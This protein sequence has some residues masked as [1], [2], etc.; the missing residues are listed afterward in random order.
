MEIWRETHIFYPFLNAYI[1]LRRDENVPGPYIYSMVYF[2]FHSY[3]KKSI[4]FLCILFCFLIF[5][6]YFLL[7][8]DP[9]ATQPSSFNWTLIAEHMWFFKHYVTLNIPP[10]VHFSSCLT[11]LQNASSNFTVL[12]HFGNYFLKKIFFIEFM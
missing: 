5:C 6:L 11:I 1:T 8:H 9:C 10:E 3:Q 7:F 12:L 4:F 2:I